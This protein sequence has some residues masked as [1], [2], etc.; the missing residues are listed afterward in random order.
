MIIPS[1]QL[2]AQSNN[3]SSIHFVPEQGEWL[4]KAESGY[5]QQEI[6]LETDDRVLELFEY[7]DF[8]Q[9]LELIR[10]LSHQSSLSLHVSYAIYG[11][12]NRQ[13]DPSTGLTHEHTDY[14][15]IQYAG[16]TYKKFFP[17][18]LDQHIAQSL[19]LNVQN[20]IVPA[21]DSNASTGGTDIMLRYQ[22]SRY[23]NFFE[24][25]GKLETIH[26]G[27]KEIERVDGE[28]EIHDSY[29]Q[30]SI[31]L[32]FKKDWGTFFSSFQAGFGLMTNYNIRGESYNGYSDKGHLLRYQ[33][34][35]GH[36]TKDWLISF[37]YSSSSENFNK[38]IEDQSTN[39]VNDPSLEYEWETVQAY[40]RLLWRI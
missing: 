20:G 18:L 5:Y 6:K 11:N 37:I 14:R 23:F 39:V 24:L 26:F 36:Q 19:R 2:L 12:L 27:K 1:G 3:L 9:S 13:Y 35:V 16:L 7:E 34:E 33:I 25:F 30:N 10:G 15:G 4:I 21:N 38:I 29:A 22:F 17:H 40:L 28:E 8:H 32:G 31:D